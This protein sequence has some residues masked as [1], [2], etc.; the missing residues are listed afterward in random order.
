MRTLTSAL[1]VA[2]MLLVVA[3]CGKEANPGWD[4]PLGPDG[5][6]IME[7]GIVYLDRAFEELVVLRTGQGAE[8]TVERQPTGASPGQMV[9]A[10]DGRSLYLINREDETL[11]IF[12]VSASSVGQ[13]TVEL[14]ST[15]DT[16]TVDPEG[17]FLLLSH[18]GDA[19]DY[20]V[21]NVNE[22]AIVDLRGGEPEVMIS[23][24][25]MQADRLEL[26]PPFEMEGQSE[27]L[28]VAM[29][30]NE[31][32]ILDLN[33]EGSDRVRKAPLTGSQADNLEPT[34]V[35]FD[36][37]TQNRPNRASLFVLDNTSDDVTQIAIQP[38]L[39][40]QTS[41]FGLSINQLAAGNRPAEIAILEL[42]AGDGG[43][44]NRLLALDGQSAQFT[45]VDVDSG[46]SATFDLPMSG[47]AHGM[48]VYQS[49]VS[50]E[51]GTEKRVL[52]Y[53]HNSPLMAVIRPQE[54]AVGTET[55]TL[56]QAVEE[57]R[58]SASPAEL[59]MESGTDSDRAVALHGGGEDG[60]SVINLRSN[61]NWW[62]SGH[63]PSQ[64]VFDGTIGYAIFGNS[65]HVVRLNLETGQPQ[66][67]DLPDRARSIYLSPDNESVLVR[68]DGASGRFTVLE[69]TAMEP[70][71]G[72]LYEHVFLGG[73]L[74]YEVFDE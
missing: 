20:V 12:D 5:P 34:A 15:Y 14:G 57:V 61:E 53:S 70:E 6:M 23:T 43:T 9:M 24:L 22:L 27:R 31:I 72:R 41:K 37:P 58:L 21:Q 66:Q 1:V 44:V 47:P 17:E 59:I 19:G 25:P 74:D 49:P 4:E 10:D 33:A 62:L 18:S 73:A 26:M 30:T 7:E 3:G 35:V 32:A 56:G 11:S 71:N 54:I 67:F 52:V 40:G 2:A 50:G 51:D 8:L 39:E 46:E 69:R 36:P 64:I 16:F 60:L 55:P 13:T 42:D 65:S 45:L 28:A 38:T 29:A 48:E 63:N 68:H